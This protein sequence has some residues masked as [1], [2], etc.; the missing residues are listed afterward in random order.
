MSYIHSLISHS[1]LDI[2][3]DEKIIARLTQS[4]GGLTSWYSKKY[5][6]SRVRLYLELI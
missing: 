3:L 4:I 6:S 1:H 2:T 5:D